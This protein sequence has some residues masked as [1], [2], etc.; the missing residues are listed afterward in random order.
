MTSL[1][2]REVASTGGEYPVI[3]DQKLTQKFAT[4]HQPLFGGW[5]YATP[6]LKFDTRLGV[7]GVGDKE[8]ARYETKT[9]EKVLLFMWPTK[10]GWLLI[11]GTIA[12]A[13]GLLWLLLARRSH[14]RQIKI[15]AR[16]YTVRDGDTIQ[17][18]AQKLHVKWQDIARL[19]RLSAPYEI[20]TG[21]TLLL[22]T[23]NLPKRTDGTK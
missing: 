9:G 21:Q 15:S 8:G 3:P 22:P 20:K 5:Y 2:G 19:N 11:I 4:A 1:F 6:S 17:D 7:Y 16:T 13:V 12:V 18:L 23:V 10:T 14:R